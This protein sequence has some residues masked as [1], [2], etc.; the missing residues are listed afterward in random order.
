MGKVRLTYVN[1]PS[2]MRLAPNE[3]ATSS[4]EAWNCFAKS[5][6]AGVARVHSVFPTLVVKTLAGT[7]GD[8]F[9]DSTQEEKFR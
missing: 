7:I 1:V 8:R 4:T 2:P 6:K 5:T 3:E 9:D